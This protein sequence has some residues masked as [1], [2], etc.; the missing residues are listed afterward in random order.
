MMA[1]YLLLASYSAEGSKGFLLTPE[2]IDQAS[3]KS[4]TYTPPGR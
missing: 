3:R 1:K 2:D 4:A